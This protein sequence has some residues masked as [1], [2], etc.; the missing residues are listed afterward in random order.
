MLAVGGGQGGVVEL[1]G[2]EGV[3]EG[4]EGH[5]VAPAGREV[6]D[7][8]VLRGDTRRRRRQTEVRL[9]WVR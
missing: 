2:E 5:A 8:D 9:G 7:V 6:L 4:A 3:D 1:S